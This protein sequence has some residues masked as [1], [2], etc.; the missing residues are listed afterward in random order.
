MEEAK[1]QYGLWGRVHMKRCPL[2]INNLLDKI[3]MHHRYR[4]TAPME[5]RNNITALLT[6]M[7]RTGEYMPTPSFCAAYGRINELSFQVRHE[8]SA[9]D[10]C[11]VANEMLAGR[12]YRRRRQARVLPGT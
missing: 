3:E 10:P 4:S 8:P 6:E 12:R 9:S 5:H 1:K 2:N 11:S 7:M